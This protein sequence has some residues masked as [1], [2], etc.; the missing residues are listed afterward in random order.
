MD[1]LIH[2]ILNNEAAIYA[3]EA[4]RMVRD[5]QET[6]KT[7]PVATVALGRTIVGTVLLSAMLKNKGD[8]ITVSINGGGPAGTIMAVGGADL[9]VKG[10]IAN[11]QVNV[12]PDERG[13]LNVAGA[14]GKDGVVTVIRDQGLKEPYIGKTPIETGE[15]AEDLA[16]YLLKSEQQP[17]VVYL[18]TWLEEDLSV[19][20]AG[21]IIISPL[22]GCSEKTLSAIEDRICEIKNYALHLMQ[23]TPE[24]E[25]KRLF[26]GMD[27]KI[28][29]SAEPKFECDCSLQRICEALIAIGPAEL[30]DMLEKDKGAQITCRFCNREYNIGETE[31]QLL[32][33]KAVGEKQ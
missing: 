29:S 7:W 13:G 3:C 4:T 28:L 32:I 26:A 8:R 19:L 17:S 21:G 33:N 20:N 6:H 2:A 14:V 12:E 18:N 10:Y 16:Y 24:E 23:Y 31:L 1:T 25:I 27:V 5:A 9:R 11:P 22:P 30:C 15:I